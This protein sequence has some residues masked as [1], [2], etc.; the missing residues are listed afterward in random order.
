MLRAGVFTRTIRSGK[1]GVLIRLEVIMFLG[2]I[3]LTFQMF[4]SVHQMILP[5]MRS[6]VPFGLTAKTAFRADLTSK[7]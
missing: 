3:I 6:T 4:Y 2:A 7:Q 1:S 5:G